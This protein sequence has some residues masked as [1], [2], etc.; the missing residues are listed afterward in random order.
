I[1]DN[2]GTLEGWTLSAKQNSAFT[3]ATKGQTLE[4]T[5]IVFQNASAVTAG[6]S[7]APTSLASVTFGTV[8]ESHNVM[9]AATDQGAGKW[10]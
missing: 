4:G 1:T 10:S 6:Q 8:G 3:S 7:A 5:E 2:R 9:V